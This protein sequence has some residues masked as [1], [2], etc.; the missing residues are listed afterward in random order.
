MRIT[1]PTCQTVYNLDDKK[2]PVGGATLKCSRCQA[3]FP[4]KKVSATAATEVGAVPLPGGPIAGG[5]RATMAFGAA[6]PLPGGPGPAAAP[7]PIPLPGTQGAGPFPLAPPAGGSGFDMPPLDNEPTRVAVSY[8]QVVAASGGAVP[9]PGGSPATSDDGSPVPLPGDGSGLPPPDADAFAAA[10]PPPMV[11]E[12][13]FDFDAPPPPSPQ[14]PTDFG[15]DGAPPEVAAPPADFGMDFDIP[16]PPAPAPEPVPTEV[17]GSSVTVSERLAA[18]PEEPGATVGHRMPGTG[19]IDFGDAPAEPAP[20][21]AAAPAS[22]DPDFLDLD[23]GA[24]AKTETGPALP[25][26]PPPAPAAEPATAAPGIDALE[27]DPTAGKDSREADLSKLTQPASAKDDLELLDF[28]DDAAKDVPGAKPAKKAAVRYQVRRKSGKVFGPFDEDALAK[29]LGAG[30]LLGSEDVSSDATH[31]VPIGSV[32]AFGGVIQK[33]MES[34]LAAPTAPGG[35]AV[36]EEQKRASVERLKSIYGDRMAAVAIVEQTAGSNLVLRLKKRLPIVV[37]LMGVLAIAGVGVYLGFTPYGFFGMRKLFPKSLKPGTPAHA[38]FVES[39][40]ILWGDSHA[41]YQKTLAAAQQTLAADEALVEARALFVQAAWAL[42][43]R[44]RAGLGHLSR[45]ERYLAELEVSS[46]DHPEVLK[47][48]AAKALAQGGDVELRPGLETAGLRAADDPEFHFLLAESH[49][50]SRDASRAQA[51]LDK[52]EKVAPNLARTAHLAAA[53]KGL[54]GDAAAALELYQAALARDPQHL[55]SAIDAAVLLIAQDRHDE[56]DALIA[57]P[58]AGGANP[59]LA[60][61][62]RAQAHVLRGMVLATR[63]KPGDAAA[64]FQ[65]ALKADPDSAPAKAAYGRFLLTRRDFAEASKLFRAAY[66]A[67]PTQIEYVEGLVRALVGVGNFK[68]AAAVLGEVSQKLPGNARVA[69]LNGHVAEAADKVDDIESNY[70][71]AAKAD[72]ALVAANLA[73]GTYYLGSRRFDD[74]ARQLAEAVKKAP[75]R[76]EVHSALGDLAV[77]R[78]DLAAAAAAYDEAL[79]LDPGFASAHLGRGQVLFQKDDVPAARTAFETALANDPFVPGGRLKFGTLLW[80]VG[81]HAEAEKE[82]EAARAMTPRD[83]DTLMRLGAVQYALGKHAEALK[84]LDAALNLDATNADTYFYKALAHHEKHESLLAID[85]MKLA[86]DRAP[87]NPEYLTQ[88]GNILFRADRFPEAVE[89]WDAAV[90]IKPDHAPALIA[91]AGGYSDQGEYN[92][93]VEFYDR[94]LKVD[95]KRK[96]VVPLIGDALFRA[97]KFQKAI[98]KFNQAL[99]AD[100][101]QAA[102]HFKL[103]RAYDEMAK[104]DKAIQYYERARKLDPANVQALYFLGYAYKDKRRHDEAIQAFKTYLKARPDGDDRKEIDDQIYFLENEGG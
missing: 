34:P 38:K 48:R 78:R 7:G 72:P 32:P 99:K 83:A 97:N 55:S 76:P 58:L 85:V 77:A 75:K 25:M 40:K 44:Y 81:A 11:G 64:E 31:W 41:A 104:R 53:V 35:A 28:I 6:V 37:A 79:K 16:A 92:R 49:L 43:R 14:G 63:R 100:P 50:K 20:E 36:S 69:F 56:A 30:Q 9:L 54:A 82:L 61:S 22:T 46:R 26:E 29:M 103:G 57:T 70:L 67:A 84:T 2:I 15:I 39:R 4:V 60:P 98:D 65:L 66:Q 101:K 27:F 91:L 68:D 94:A 90:K 21:A 10:E 96:D 102:L 95:P 24:S 1:C 3:S 12:T 52:A 51:A 5:A 19:D 71:A 23:L 87:R 42:E 13:D 73:L 17:E 18:P 93:A 80:R 74:A 62:E 33:L 89:K 47:A 88:M 86:V 8:D 45:A 59:L